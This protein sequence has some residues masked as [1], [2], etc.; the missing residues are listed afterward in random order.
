MKRGLL[1]EQI[2]VLAAVQGSI[3]IDHQ[4]IGDFKNT[5]SQILKSASP[6]FANRNSS[7]K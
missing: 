6:D 2:R 5:W 4:E 3:N 1:G 7:A